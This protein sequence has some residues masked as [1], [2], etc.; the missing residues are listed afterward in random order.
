MV[1][2]PYCDIYF[3]GKSELPLEVEKIFDGYVFHSPAI[4]GRNL[5][6]GNYLDYALPYL[7]N[8]GKLLT[9]GEVGTTL[10]HC[11]VY[12]KIIDR[13]R[14]GLIF[15]ADIDP[16]IHNIK[17]AIDLA[18][19]TQADFLHAGIH[20]DA[21]DGKFFYGRY[22][23]HLNLYEANTKVNFWG[24]FSYMVSPLAAN[25]L[26]QQHDKMLRKADDWDFLLRDC[27]L[28]AL[29][30][31]IFAHPKIRGDLEGERQNIARKIWS[32]Q[33]LRLFNPVDLLDKF[34]AV[35]K[36][37]LARLLFKPIPPGNLEDR[38]QHQPD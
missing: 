33:Y 27:N 16:Y 23:E 22:V 6:A 5:L 8:Y 28:S 14:P 36:N 19:E 10:A 17:H 1:S 15:E 26:K 9:P 2:V 31:P 13:E 12:R 11:E 30:Y 3:I 4:I 25:E 7:K 32:R 18:Y 20:P 38:R 34:S 35:F 24:A 21:Y 37:R 29:Y